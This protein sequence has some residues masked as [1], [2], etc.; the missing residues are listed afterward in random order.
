[1]DYSRVHNSQALLNIRGN[2]AAGFLVEVSAQNTA[3]VSGN[4]DLVRDRDTVSNDVERVVV[5]AV[6]VE[7]GP[8]TWPGSG[9]S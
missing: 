9:T 8:T 7:G 2:A 3:G 1:M 6:E 4:F 5:V